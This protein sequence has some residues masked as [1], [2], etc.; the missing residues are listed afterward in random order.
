N[1]SAD[2]HDDKQLAEGGSRWNWLYAYPEIAPPQPPSRH[3]LM[4]QRAQSA[5]PQETPTATADIAGADKA[6]IRKARLSFSGHGPVQPRRRPISLPTN[7]LRSVSE[8][9]VGGVPPLS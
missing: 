7:K 6:A 1:E 5:E 8:P 2:N 4:L 9:L 3:A